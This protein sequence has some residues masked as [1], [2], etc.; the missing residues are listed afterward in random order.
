VRILRPLLQRPQVPALHN[1]LTA[2]F[3]MVN[4]CLAAGGRV[5]LRWAM[6]T[7]ASCGAASTGAAWH[8]IALL[9]RV[10]GGAETACFCPVCAET[11]FAYFT[12]QRERH[13]K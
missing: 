1:G 6:L 11:Q 13:A 5:R 7:C 3:R 12:K 4:A 8:W 2:A 10:P 9:R